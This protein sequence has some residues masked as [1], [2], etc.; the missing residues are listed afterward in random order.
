MRTRRANV[1]YFNRLGFSGTTGVYDTPMRV[2]WIYKSEFELLVRLAGFRV[3]I[4]YSGFD[5][6]PYRGEGEMVRVLGKERI[7]PR[8]AA[9]S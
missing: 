9:D 8:A 5:R 1:K 6:S 4:L 7:Q 3:L 2:R